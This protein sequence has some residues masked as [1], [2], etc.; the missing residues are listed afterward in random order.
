VE[1]V[2]PLAYL[3]LVG[4]TIKSAALVVLLPALLCGLLTPHFELVGAAVNR[5]TLPAASALAALAC[6]FFAA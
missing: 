3:I 5:W 2:L 6:F 1:L 4:L